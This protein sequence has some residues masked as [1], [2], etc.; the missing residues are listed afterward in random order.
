MR[1]R[2]LKRWTFEAAEIYGV[3]PSRIYG[4]YHRGC[5]SAHN[6]RRINA[7]VVHVIGEPKLLRKPVIGPPVRFNFARVDWS[8]PDR[9]IAARLGCCR[10]LVI[11]RRHDE[12][13]A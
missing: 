3:S 12:R 11:E 6:F 8:Q 2:L 7:R 13:Q 5:F 9:G 1:L 10:S 4:W